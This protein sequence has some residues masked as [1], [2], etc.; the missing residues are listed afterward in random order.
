MHT[1]AEKMA[2]NF[3]SAMARV[4]R[5]GDS[6]GIKHLQNICQAVAFPGLRFLSWLSI[7][8]DIQFLKNLPCTRPAS[9]LSENTPGCQEGTDTACSA[10][11]VRCPFYSVGSDASYN[12]GTVYS[13]Q[14]N[15]FSRK[16]CGLTIF[17]RTEVIHG[18][19]RFCTRSKNSLRLSN[20]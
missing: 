17:L 3:R 1:A 11:Q 8:S 9:W 19:F 6:K 13:L 14:T 16:L 18:L 7:F 4:Y 2:D 10:K 12:F 5:I 15:L 20:F